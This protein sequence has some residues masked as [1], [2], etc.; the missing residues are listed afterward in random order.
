MDFLDALNENDGQEFKRIAYDPSPH[1]RF[2]LY[3]FIHERREI[4][5]KIALNRVPVTQEVYDKYKEGI[6]KVVKRESDA[7]KVFNEFTIARTYRTPSSYRLALPGSSIKGSISTAY[8]EKLYKKS[9][10]YDSVKR[11]MLTP[12]EDNLFRHLLIADASAKRESAAIAYVKNVKRNI[13]REC[14]SNLLEVIRADTVFE[15][16]ITI[17]RTL[18]IGDIASGCN[19]HYK[20]IL[21]SMFDKK[22]DPNTLRS[23]GSDFAAKQAQLQLANNHFLLRIGRHSGARACTVDGMRRIKVKTAAQNYE[24]GDEETTVWLYQGN[25]PKR[26]APLGWFLCEYRDADN[27]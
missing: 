17:K 13:E 11:Q 23:I 22:T 19:S 9:G 18:E 2:R 10:N 20:P 6:G 25:E 1:A 4:A 12:G 3:G 16:T 15:T 5:K 14:I 7:E 27:I 26:A 24:I 21:Y 8:Q